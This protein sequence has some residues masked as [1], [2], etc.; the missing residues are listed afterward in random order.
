M[1]V[2]IHTS[3]GWITQASPPGLPRRF[4]LRT[5]FPWV[6][7]RARIPAKLQYEPR[8]D[9]L[10]HGYAYAQLN[11]SCWPDWLPTET[12]FLPQ[13]V[14]PRLG[15]RRRIVGRGTGRLLRLISLHSFRAM[16]SPVWQEMTASGLCLHDSSTMQTS[17]PYSHHYITT[18]ATEWQCNCAAPPRKAMD[19]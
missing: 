19:V 3:L 8:V 17:M 9:I 11:T 4:V 15:R 14:E 10:Q 16:F 1:Q 7:S 2:R 12:L 18:A 13:N 5:V 6:A